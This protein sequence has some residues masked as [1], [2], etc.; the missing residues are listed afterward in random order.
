MVN[1]A[2]RCDASEDIGSGHVMRCLTLAKQLE[3]V[4]ISIFFLCRKEPGNLIKLLE[5]DFHVLQLCESTTDKRERRKGDHLEREWCP[6]MQQEDGQECLRLLR[7]SGIYDVDWIIVDHYRIGAAWQRYFCKEMSGT[8]GDTRVMVIDDLANRFHCADILLDQNFFGE[9]TAGRY[10]G[11]V[12]NHC[13]MLLGPKYALLGAEYGPMHN[14]TRIR[15]ELR[16]IL[17]F[18]GGSDTKNLTGR[19]LEALNCRDFS[20]LTIDVVI[21]AQ[22]RHK[23]LI[24]SQSARH[25]YINLYQSLPSLAGLMALA[26][27]CIGAGGSTC[28]ERSCLGVPSIVISTSANQ[29]PVAKALDRAGQ[30]YF[31]GSDADVTIE[32]IRSTVLDLRNS[33]SR[34]ERLMSLTDGLGARRVASL[35]VSDR[36]SSDHLIRTG[37]EA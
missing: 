9:D 4:D 16:R 29:L 17:V 27:L 37:A 32:K 23:A 7:S 11:L 19:T 1:I 35:I 33:F 15:K 24:S 5:K 3:R 13:K 36:D 2:F 26:D 18:F 6:K 10:R 14:L 22:S 12:P 31:L 20:N 8:R 25:P 30:I 21:G 28:W 34:Q